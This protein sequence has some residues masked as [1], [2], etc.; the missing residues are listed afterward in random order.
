MHKTDWFHDKKWGVFLFYV[1]DNQNNPQS[2]H[3]MGAGETGW[4]EC[5]NDFDVELFAKQLADVHAGY[6]MITLMQTS[7]YLIAPNE[8]FDKITGYKPGEA[9]SKTD[10]VLKLYDA[11]SKYN[12]D[13]ILYFTGDGPSRDS[14]ASKAFGTI[15]YG[16]TDQQVTTEFV[17]K[18]AGVAKEYSERYGDKIKGWW[19]DGCYENIGYDEEKLTIMA[20]AMKAGNP[21]A[22][23]ASN[24]YGC[25]DEYAVLLE[26]VR[27]GSPVDDYTAGELVDFKDVP[28][29]PFIIGSRWH[30][31]SFLGV[32][33]NRVA[34][35]GW[36]R[37]GSKYTGQYM[38]DYIE[39]VYDLGGIVTMDI[40]VY[41][42][43]HI[44]PE[45]LEVL[46]HLKGGKQYA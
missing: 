5:I 42:D 35:D 41:R 11:L 38:H 45:Q 30:I 17:T 9:C 19:L 29:D 26:H 31:L 36:G 13:L 20:N 14:I 2:V 4:D 12:I 3:N 7:K 16:V 8:T 10:F 15:E 25:M 43:G 27:M 44:D 6:V 24:Y 28:F 1:Y 40:C 22:L 34:Y 18:W 21:D 39:D 46:S 23:I 32:P 37:P 33:K